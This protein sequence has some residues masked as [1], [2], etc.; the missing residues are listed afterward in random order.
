MFAHKS[1]KL[2][3]AIGVEYK[4]LNF[5]ALEYAPNNLGNEI[6]ASVQERF[7]EAA[8]SDAFC[9]SLAPALAV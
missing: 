3:K 5:D 2:L 4:A 7:S 8:F 1:Q 6:R 9:A